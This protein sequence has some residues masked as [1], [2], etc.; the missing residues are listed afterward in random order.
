[1]DMDPI[2][3]DGGLCQEFDDWVED[4]VDPEWTKEQKEE[5]YEQC[6]WWWWPLD[7]EEIK[8]F[9]ERSNKL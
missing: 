5:Y 6:E 3:Y 1:M 4:G 9:E 2:A 7:D 8:E